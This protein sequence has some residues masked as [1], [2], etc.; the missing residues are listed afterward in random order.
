MDFSEVLMQASITRVAIVDDDL[1]RNIT[2]PDLL[3]IH[4]DL[5]AL[6]SDPNDPD[7]QQYQEL[8]A[9]LG[10]D[11]DQ[12]EDKATPLSDPAIA[13]QAP[14][15]LRQAAEQVLEARASNAE[16]V[17]R[18]HAL[19]ISAGISENNIDKYS[20]P[21]IP[22]DKLYDLIIVDYFLVDNSEKK[23]LPFI[24]EMI[25]SHSGRE[26]PLQV[27]LMSTHEAEIKKEF[28]NFRPALG[29]TSSRMRVMGKPV[30][31]DYL[32]QWRLALLQLANDRSYINVM[33]GFIRN[34]GAAIEKAAAEQARSMW[35][36]D[37][38]AMDILHETSSRDNDNY[39][40]Y[41]EECLSR[42]LLT[43]LEEQ[44][45]MRAALTTLEEQLVAH[46]VAKV[47][48]PVA[49]IGD[50]RAAIRALMK[51]ME[52][53]GGAG[54][55]LSAYPEGGT[56]IEKAKWV[57]LNLRF[58]MVLKAADGKEWLNITQACDLAQAK[59]TDVEITTLL[60]VGGYRAHPSSS[61]AT[62]AMLQ[63]N[64]T[65]TD[66][67]AQVLGWNLRSVRTPSI[68][69]FGIEYEQGWSVSGELRLDLAQSIATQYGSR[70]A[71]VGLQK[72]MWS[73]R[74]QG[75]G[76]SVNAILDS[77]P[78]GPVVGVVLS[79]HGMSRGKSEEIHIDRECLTALSEEFPG[80]YSNTVH[81]HEGLQLK[82][83]GKK[84]G[85]PLILYCK[86]TPKNIRELRAELDHEQW[87][88]RADNRQK[89]I[90]ALWYA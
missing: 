54:P 16:P 81:A 64:S 11:Y 85:S 48:P 9:S 12:L 53:R 38:Q 13:A 42:N 21:Y 89:V 84:E 26:H 18:L 31:D 68:Q 88:N 75:V 49:E 29:V 1:S 23:T 20:S 19:L 15:R 51:S 52:W 59:D 35:E 61:A 8:L 57:R 86:A 24:R 10:H 33:E 79:G 70:T 82:L 28:R 41:V 3:T 34:A 77:E 80:V 46:R 60:L 40:R 43:N 69:Q 83:G 36:L 25:E 50:S 17:A 7:S 27:I 44:T 87:L 22:P 47:I 66:K 39:C 58:G 55:S 65:M 63:M 4:G 5:E 78:D 14:A 30:S 32:I 74:L 56:P 2:T 90:V 45:V 71:R 37:L 76:L 62:E 6:L 73:W 67:D 72:K